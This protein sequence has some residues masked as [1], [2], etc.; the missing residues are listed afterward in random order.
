MQGY[1]VHHLSNGEVYEGEFRK[2]RRHGN[3]KLINSLGVYQGKIQNYIGGFR[4]DTKD[5]E[6]K[7]DWNDGRSFQGSFRNGRPDGPGML[8]LSN[9]KSMNGVW[10]N[11]VLDKDSL[12]TQ[13]F[14]A[15]QIGSLG[16]IGG[17]SIIPNGESVLQNKT[18]GSLVL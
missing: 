16:A 13:S 15:S 7:F 12:D 3:G 17:T 6:G 1:G 8:L 4:N 14:A 18:R 2:N 9:G 11:G 5:G 10:V